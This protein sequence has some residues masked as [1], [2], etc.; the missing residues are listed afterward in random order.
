MF[1]TLIPLFDENMAVKG[2]F[3]KYCEENG[4]EFAE[5]SV[6][7]N[8]EETV[9]KKDMPEA[10]KNH[11]PDL[12]C[13]VSEYIKELYTEYDR[14]KDMFG[15]YK[16]AMNGIEQRMLTIAEIIDHLEYIQKQ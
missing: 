3:L 12:P 6:E 13:N 15:R 14:L 11:K 5:E 16:E 9:E 2:L 4:Y 1:A 7:Q 10:V 8:S